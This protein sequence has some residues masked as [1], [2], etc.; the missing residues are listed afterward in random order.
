ME[1]LEYDCER[2]RDATDVN[3]PIKIREDKANG[4]IVEGLTRHTFASLKEFKDLVAK[5]LRY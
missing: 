4:I 2:L 1:L 5:L 3:A